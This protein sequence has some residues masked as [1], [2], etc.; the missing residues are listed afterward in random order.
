MEI[1]NEL[2]RE[3]ICWL[4]LLE[5]VDEMLMLSLYWDEF[6]CSCMLLVESCSMKPMSLLVTTGLVHG[7][8]NGVVWQLWCLGLPNRIEENN[9]LVLQETQGGDS[10]RRGKLMDNLNGIPVRLR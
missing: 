2:M 10:N 8:C 5:L 7:D 3:R 9:K 1:L 6:C 4:M